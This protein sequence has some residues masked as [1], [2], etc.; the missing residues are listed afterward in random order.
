MAEEI[1]E[2]ELFATAAR[3][4]TVNG[5]DVN[6]WRH[7]GIRL[8]LDITAV[9]GTV[10]VLDVKVQSKDHISGKYVDIPSAAFAQKSGVGSDDLLVYP[11]VAE[12][13]NRSVSDVVPKTFR[14]VATI[15]GTTPSFTFS[16]SGEL[17]P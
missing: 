12:T 16:L 13:A 2:L 10:P 8:W 15:G 9:S 11:G 1:R 7:R 3:T 4:A 5:S 6:N 17:L 14:V